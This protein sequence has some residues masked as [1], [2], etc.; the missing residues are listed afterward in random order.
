MDSVHD[1]QFGQLALL[2][3]SAGQQFSASKET[4]FE[5]VKLMTHGFSIPAVP[6]LNHYFHFQ[7]IPPDKMT[8][9]NRASGEASQRRLARWKAG[10]LQVLSVTLPPCH[11]CPHGHHI[12]FFAPTCPVSLWSGAELF[13]LK[14]KGHQI[15]GEVFSLFPK[16][17]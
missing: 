1:H 10:P 13:G 16:I 6:N 2:N 7:I 9:H 5:S 3:T 4:F 11:L 8:S 15:R 12:G 17:F 14:T